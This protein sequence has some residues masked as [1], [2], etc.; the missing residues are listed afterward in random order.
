[1]ATR[2]QPAVQEIVVP[3]NMLPLQVTGM[4]AMASKMW[5][6]FI[7]MGFM[8]VV[9]AL[10]IGVIVS[11]TAADY[12]SFS[13]LTREAAATGSDLAKEKAFIESTMAWLPAFK[14]LGVGMIL[15]G[16]TFLLATIL[17]ALRSVA[18]G[19]SRLWGNRCE[20]PSL[21]SRPK[22]SRWS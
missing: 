14:F 18:P 13:K 16:V 19:S 5:I 3:A 6:P 20:C 17:G 1:M 15:G 7:A 9:A 10:V 21:R 8:I 4:Q 2:A 12:F 22:C 11:V